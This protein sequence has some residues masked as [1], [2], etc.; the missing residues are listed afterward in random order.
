[1]IIKIHA[2]KIIIILITV[3]FYFFSTK[4]QRPQRKLF[5]SVKVIY[6]EVWL[7]AFVGR[8]SISKMK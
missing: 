5:D 7:R 6:S 1:M 4:A 2:D 3:Q 8:T